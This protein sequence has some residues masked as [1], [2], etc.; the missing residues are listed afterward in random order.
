MNNLGVHAY[1]LRRYLLDAE[2]V[3]ATAVVDVGPGFAVDTIALTL[4]RCD[5]SALAYVNA[6]QSVPYSQPNLSI[7]GTEGTVLGRNVT[8]PN[9]TG[10]ISVLGGSGKHRAPGLHRRRLRGHRGQV[11][12]WVLRGHG[13]AA[14]EP[15]GRRPRRVRS[16]D[17]VARAAPRGDDRQQ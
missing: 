13:T 12:R 7:Y 14:G 4:L 15:G 17:A 3:E 16:G 5:T 6:N 8:R 2:V 1:D 10:S 11:R 9:L